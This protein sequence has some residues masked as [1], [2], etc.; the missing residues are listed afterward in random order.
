MKS[1]NQA[2]KFTQKVFGLLLHKG[3]N[4]RV[5]LISAGVGSRMLPVTEDIPKC[6][7]KSSSGPSLLDPQ[8]KSIR[9]AGIKNITVI[10][11]YKAELIE[12][13]IKR[14]EGTNINAVYNP[15]YAVS[16]NLISLW[17]AR[18]YMDEDIITIN[19]DNIFHS[20]IL[21][22]LIRRKNDIVLSMSK[23]KQYDIDDMKI[24]HRK[25]KLV[26]IGKNLP[27]KNANGESIG[28]IRYSK[29]GINILRD[30]L[31]FMVRNPKN[32]SLFYLE[33]IQQLV[34]DGIE[35][36]L[37]EVNG[38]MWAELDFHIDLKYINENYRKFASKASKIIK[39]GI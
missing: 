29:K 30:K 31:D 7:I 6:L 10:V 15:F 34:N 18:N 39:S 2:Q 8:I 25:G 17:F 32:H 16:N 21:S 23:K 24:I 33:A 11:G 22:S 19:G 5:I 9:A 26:E 27:Y 12:E 4:M 3:D 38:D 20:N 13:K 35:V 14:I 1:L 37:E 36:Y 28:I